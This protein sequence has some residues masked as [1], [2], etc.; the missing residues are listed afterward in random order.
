MQQSHPRP[1]VADRLPLIQRLQRPHT[2]FSPHL[3]PR[4]ARR[5]ARS[6]PAGQPHTAR[7]PR[8]Q[9][10]VARPSG[11]D[12]VC[13]ENREKPRVTRFRVLPPWPPGGG[14]GA[15]GQGVPDTSQL[16][17]EKT[18]RNPAIAS[19]C[20]K[21]IRAPGPP[22]SGLLAPTL[23]APPHAIFFA[24][25][26]KGSAQTSTFLPC[27]AAANRPLSAS[28]A[29]RRPPIGRRYSVYGKPRKAARHAIPHPAP[30]A[31]WRGP[32]GR[33]LGGARYEPALA[34]KDI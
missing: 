22:C 10:R 11:A 30:L 31:P 28:S 16:W 7:Q 6:Y 33:G 8:R 12:T 34:R 15:G 9:R 1:R 18:Y 26:A 23:A 14:L 29:P 24:S 25:P 3:P 21:A 19:Q 32:R 17:L 27:G 13:T 20:R 4:A 2:P 5:Q